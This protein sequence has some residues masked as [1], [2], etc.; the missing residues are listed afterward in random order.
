[1][2]KRGRRIGQNVNP[3]DERGWRIPRPGTVRRRVYEMMLAGKSVPQITKALDISYICCC[4]HQQ[5]IKKPDRTN[6]LKYNLEHPDAPIPVP[7]E[8]RR[9][10]KEMKVEAVMSDIDEAKAYL[11]TGGLGEVVGL[12]D[13]AIKA[14]QTKVQMDAGM[15]MAL[16]ILANEAL[17]RRRAH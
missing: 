2:A 9:T 16:C 13:L 1:M 15:A 12:T 14:G 11:E 10:M 17:R 6:A 7:G 5:H 4:M 3:R 8:A